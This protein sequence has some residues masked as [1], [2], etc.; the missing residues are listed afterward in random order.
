MINPAVPFEIARQAH[1]ALD[2]AERRAA[3]SRRRTPVPALTEES[4]ARWEVE[5][6]D[7]VLQNGYTEDGEENLLQVFVVNLVNEYGERFRFHKDFFELALAERF[8]LRALMALA[9]GASPRESSKWTKGN[10]VYGSLYY[11]HS[12]EEGATLAWELGQDLS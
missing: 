4:R 5:I 12:N 3:A 8:S 2:K 9:A 6:R 7:A 11:E 10:P 1:E